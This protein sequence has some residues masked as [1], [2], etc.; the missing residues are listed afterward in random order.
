MRRSIAPERDGKGDKASGRQAV[1]NAQ[2]RVHLVAGYEGIR[3]L[4][5]PT[6][7]APQVFE[8]VRSEDSLRLQR[9]KS[10]IEVCNE[11][12]PVD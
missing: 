6:V 2:R 11:P 3:L 7:P 9:F 4:R 1:L 8:A 5:V 12:C 10:L